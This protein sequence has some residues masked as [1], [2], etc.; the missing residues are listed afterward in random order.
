MQLA[1]GAADHLAVIGIPIGILSA[2]RPRSLFDRVAMGFALFGVSVA[3]VL[4]RAARA[5]TSSGSS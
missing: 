4:P 1:I 3:G 5:S 2:L